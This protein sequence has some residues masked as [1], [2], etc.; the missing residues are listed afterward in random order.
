MGRARY[1]IAIGVLIATFVGGWVAALSF[2]SPEQ[3]QAAASPPEAGPIVAPVTSGRLADEITARA[4]IGRRSHQELRL[5]ALPDHATVTSVVAASGKWVRPGAV[6]LTLNG[7]PLF[8]MPGSFDFYRDLSP[9][10]EGLDVAQLQSGL[11]QAG[12]YIPE[13]ESGTFGPATE[14]AVR[15]LYGASGFEPILRQGEQVP[16]APEG[17]PRRPAPVPPLVPIVPLTEVTVVPRLPAVLVS[18]PRVGVTPTADQAVATLAS[19]PLVAR[20]TVVIQAASRLAVDMPVML[21]TDD[22]KEVKATITSVSADGPSGDASV[23]ASEP[24]IIISPRSPLPAGW[25][26]KNVLARIIVSVQSEKALLVPSRAVAGGVDGE[27][28][29]LKRDANGTFVRIPVRELSTFA[30][31]SAVE[32]VEPGALVEG[33][34]VRVE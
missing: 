5:S 9:G 25:N 1:I 19:G 2:Q 20:A 22:G 11:A 34:T 7:R 31:R 28:A 17:S 29:V 16:Q 32:P 18:A 10:M 33:D 14:R 26:G 27:A 8:V 12:H 4:D 21:S 30:G 24:V 3:R 13:Y 15:D 23:E 6:L